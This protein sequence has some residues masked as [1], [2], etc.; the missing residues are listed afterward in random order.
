MPKLGLAEAAPI[1]AAEPTAAA[2]SQFK[3]LGAAALSRYAVQDIEVG[4]VATG[5]AATAAQ[6]R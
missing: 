2:L 5:L 3:V 1:G 4:I 6:P